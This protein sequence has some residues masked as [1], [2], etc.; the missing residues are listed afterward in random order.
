MTDTKT[1]PKKP[2]T[3][4]GDDLDHMYCCDE[5]LALCGTDVTDHP[6]IDLSTSPKLCIVC[7]D[8]EWATC[9]RCGN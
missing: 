5:N 2:D 7:I 9:E 6:V 1:A 3:T 4:A 8:L